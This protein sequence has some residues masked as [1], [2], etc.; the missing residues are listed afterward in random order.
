MGSL[1]DEHGRARAPVARD[2]LQPASFRQWGAASMSP[3][4]KAVQASISFLKRW[5]RGGPWVITAIDP[6]QGYIRTGGF[7]DF[8]QSED[9]LRDFILEWRGRRNLYFQVN[10]DHR[11]IINKKSRKEHIAAV[12]ALHADI[13]TYKAGEDRDASFAAALRQLTEELPAGIPGPPSVI[14]NSGNGLNAF[15]LL[16][17]P[18]VVG[19]DIA[20]AEE[21]ERHN[22]GIAMALGGDTI[23]DVTRI[24]RLPW[25]INLPNRNKRTMGLAPVMA[26]QIF[27]DGRLRYDLDQFPVVEG[28]GVRAT[29]PGNESLVSRLHIGQGVRTGSLD[30]LRVPDRTKVI[31]ALGA[32]GDE[33]RESRSDWLFSA[34]LSMLR[35]GESDATVLGVITDAR[36][37]ISDSVL[38]KADPDYHARRQIARA[39][40]W[41]STQLEQEFDE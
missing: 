5:Q 40:A 13:D 1:D 26:R 24:M 18:V 33:V 8:W 39:H 32:Y 34:I 19:G 15:W 10:D 3:Q 20:R 2:L 16:R 7:G 31:V 21:V 23:T 4:Q 14:N 25:S 12:V 29:A 30:D 11:A 38:D 6:D 37:R 28:K 36:W 17:E 22:R 9:A 35:C 27:F 41:L